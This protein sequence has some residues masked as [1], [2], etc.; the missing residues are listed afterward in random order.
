M[1]PTK[2]SIGP[3]D[4]YQQWLRSLKSLPE[5]EAAHA[6]RTA[7]L[8]GTRSGGLTFTRGDI[9]QYFDL[10]HRYYGCPEEDPCDKDM[11]EEPLCWEQ[12]LLVPVKDIIDETGGYDLFSILRL[13]VPVS[14]AVLEFEAEIS[15][16]WLKKSVAQ[17]K[18]I[19]L[20][21]DSTLP[22]KHRPDIDRPVLNS[23]PHQ[24]HSYTLGHYAHPHLNLQDLSTPNALL[25]LLNARGRH[26]P[27]DFALLDYEMAP[28]I[29][30]RP[31]ILEKTKYTV[32]LSIDNYGEILEWDTEEA[33]SESMSR[34]KTVHPLIALHISSIQARMYQFLFRCILAIL[35]TRKRD[36]LSNLKNLDQITRGHATVGGETFGQRALIED[37]RN[38]KSCTSKDDEGVLEAK[39]HAMNIPDSL[40]LVCDNQDFTSLN[41]IVREACYRV[42]TLAD[43]ARLEALVSACKDAAEDHFW[44][45]RE[46]PGYFRD[47]TLEQR[48]HRPELL[49]CATCN[50]AHKNADDDFLLPRVLHSVV[51]DCYIDLFM[52]NQV[53]VRISNLHRLSL[54]HKD[55]LLFGKIGFQEEIPRDFFEAL[56]E[57]W[58][59]LETFQLEV[60]HELK[61][62]WASSPYI[63]SYHS[64]DCSGDDGDLVVR[65][66]RVNK[67]SR[68]RDKELEHILK[69]F[70]YL[71]EPPVRQSL[72]TYTLV[73]TLEQVLQTSD[74][75]SSLTSP[76]TAALLSKLSIVTECHRQLSFFLPWA[77]QIQ[78]AVKQRQT[79]LL[80]AYATNLAQWHATLQASFHNTNLSEL[81]KPGSKFRYPVRKR[82]SKA[83]VQTLRAAEAALDA[84][85]V[86]ADARFRECTGT[87]PHDMVSDILTKRTL[88]RTPPWAEPEKESEPST[89]PLEYL[90]IPLSNHV[91]DPATQITGPFD[92]LRVSGPKKPK[93]GSPTTLNHNHMHDSATKDHATTL[94]T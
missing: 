32:G 20:A 31:A 11:Q 2:Y 85:W 75:A 24:R 5:T 22:P 62:A 72:K 81:G 89:P 58:F 10:V 82:R 90:Y 56:V 78:Y 46:D 35:P 16:C 79:E 30:L 27:W 28:L 94:T 21:A 45:L 57:T 91:H 34:G 33:A 4:H 7:L 44:L 76:L 38:T 18:A 88:Q 67:S 40:P 52:W 63:R 36:I 69:L 68:K 49:R 53:H 51:A 50:R 1:S 74:R 70:Q 17:R 8:R 43:I 66:K 77:K 19:L 13:W 41:N 26:L 6:L 92:R 55:K 83:N 37:V 60:I 15:Q 23:C 71:L 3:A 12:S 14:Y 65:I 54:Q 47:F 80:I 48:E 87:T 61:S 86:A 64:Q 9:F 39:S 29:H 59:F 84:F 73:Q 25:I 93:C 42:P